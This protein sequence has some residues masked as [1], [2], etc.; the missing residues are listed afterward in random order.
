MQPPSG[1]TFD[2]VSGITNEEPVI[3]IGED[4]DGPVLELDAT[5]W[6]V[7]ALAMALRTNLEQWPQGVSIWIDHPSGETDD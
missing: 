7:D 1:D 5:E 4:R 3:K 2:D 6:S